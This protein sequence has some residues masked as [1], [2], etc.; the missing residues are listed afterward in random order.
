VNAAIKQVM[1]HAKPRAKH[2]NMN[3][4][5]VITACQHASVES[6]GKGGRDSR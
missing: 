3:L 4:T 2:L 1:C 5:V 6:R